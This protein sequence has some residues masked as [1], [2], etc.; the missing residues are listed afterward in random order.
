MSQTS[1]SMMEALNGARLSAGVCAI[2]A[3]TIIEQS[4]TG[5]SS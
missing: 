4:S 5:F 3:Q 2:K 1:L